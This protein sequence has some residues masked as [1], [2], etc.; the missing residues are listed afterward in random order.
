MLHV[1]LT[2]GL[3]TR[4]SSVEVPARQSFPACLGAEMA[5]AVPTGRSPW[6][7]DREAPGHSWQPG[8]PDARRTVRSRTRQSLRQP[9]P[10]AHLGL[11]RAARLRDAGRW[12]GGSRSLE[13]LEAGGERQ[14]TA[15]CWARARRVHSGQAWRP[16]DENARFP[17]PTSW[18]PG[19][20]S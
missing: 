9:W 19:F 14:A 6:F 16:V 13:C 2:T 3:P 15:Q 18:W 12:R 7:G 20:K 11:R 10:P 17:R 4:F 1:S 8:E 5:R